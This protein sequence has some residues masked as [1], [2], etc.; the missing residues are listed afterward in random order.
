MPH[1]R[2]YFAAAHNGTVLNVVLF[3]LLK[4]STYQYGA[5]HYIR[6]KRPWTCYQSGLEPNQ[7]EKTKSRVRYEHEDPL[8]ILCFDAKFLYNTITENYAAA[9]VSNK[10]TD[11][12][13]GCV[14]RCRK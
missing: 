1:E 4:L 6:N 12:Q 3:E 9:K 8:Q 2:R 5:T 13:Q 14:F 11:Q 10:N 7:I